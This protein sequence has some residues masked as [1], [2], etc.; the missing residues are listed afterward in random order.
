MVKSALRGLGVS[1][2]SATLSRSM[3][4]V[5]GYKRR[6][7]RSGVVP[8]IKTTLGRRTMSNATT[9]ALSADSGRT[10][11]LN[12]EVLATL[13]VDIPKTARILDFGCGNGTMVRALHTLGYVNAEGY[14]VVNYRGTPPDADRDHITAGTLLELRLPYEDNTFD[15]VISDQVFEHVQDQVRAFQELHRITKPGGHGMHIIPAR[16][17]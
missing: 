12:L 15:L 10:R 14:D 5:Y 11:I 4:I 1:R 8:P 16:Y 9:E 17:A 6:G 7:C 13:G 3:D 2:R